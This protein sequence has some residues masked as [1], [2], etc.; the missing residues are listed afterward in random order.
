MTLRFKP[1][2][3]FKRTEVKALVKFGSLAVSSLIEALKNESKYIR[4]QA[5]EALGEIGG[6][7]SL[8]QLQILAQND[9]E[10]DVRSTAQKALKKI[11]GTE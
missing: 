9:P 8:E 3:G 4:L 7:M 2:I 11:Q 10:L 1:K 6:T 5:A